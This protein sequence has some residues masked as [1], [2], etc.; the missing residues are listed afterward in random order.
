MTTIPQRVLGQA[1]WRSAKKFPHKTAIISKGREYSY[2]ELKEGAER[3]A[4]HLVR[5]GIKKGD[6][7]AIYMN[8]SWESIVSIYGVTLVRPS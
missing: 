4:C 8:N 3:M 7:I 1:L 6:R 5:A 2:A